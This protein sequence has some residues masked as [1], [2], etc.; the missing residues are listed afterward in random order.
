MEAKM[1]SDTEPGTETDEYELVGMEKLI[2]V[3]ERL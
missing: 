2:S 3:C 1:E